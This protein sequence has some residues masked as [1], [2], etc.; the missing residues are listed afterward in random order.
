MYRRI[1]AALAALA[2]SAATA[3][4]QEPAAP[5]ALPPEVAAYVRD[6]YNAPATLRHDGRTRIAEDETVR[7]D[8]AVADGPLVVAG[9]I[10]GDVVVING[11]AE[12]LPGAAITGALTVVGGEAA[13]V[14]GRTS[15]GGCGSTRRGSPTAAATTASS[16]WRGWATIPP[17]PARPG[18]PAAARWSAAS[19]GRRLRPEHPGHVQPH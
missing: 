5:D 2:L 7:G 19:A 18:V 15:A 11:D 3:H 1:M 17:R 4:G 8:L 14:D 16:G 10:E 6:L 12:L 9:R 13:G